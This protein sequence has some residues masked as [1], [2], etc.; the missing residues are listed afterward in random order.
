MGAS[1]RARDYSKDMLPKAGFPD[2]P[3]TWDDVAAAAE[4]IKADGNFGFGVQAKGIE[5]DVYYYYALWA[6]GGDVVGPDNKAAF[7]SP[8][9]LAA[10]AAFPVAVLR[11][12]VELV[13]SEAEPTATLKVPGVLLR[14]AESPMAVLLLP[15]VLA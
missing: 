9:V 4:K 5:V 14:S 10:S 15:L 11:R 8:A 2:G 6:F 3:A 7:A 12:P 13:A 1:S